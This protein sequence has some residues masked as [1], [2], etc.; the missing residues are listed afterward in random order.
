[1]RIAQLLILIILSSYGFA[2]RFLEI[3]KEELSYT[4]SYFGN[5]L[6]NEGMRLGVESPKD[7]FT[8]TKKGKDLEILKSYSASLNGY[9]DNGAHTGVFI[10][11][12]WSKKKLYP[13]RFNISSSL[14]PMGVYRSFLPET[15]KVDEDGEINKVFL[16]GRFY[17]ASSASAGIGRVNKKKPDN[18]WHARVNVTALYPYSRAIV[19]LVNIE[20]GYHFKINTK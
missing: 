10:T 16:P 3:N 1:M 7:Q 11:A 15:Y 17:L 4:I 12:G 20:L 9:R 19:P 6:W 5:N 2:Q 14:E 8:K 18:G 13:N